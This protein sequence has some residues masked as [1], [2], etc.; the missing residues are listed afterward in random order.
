MIKRFWSRCLSQF[1]QGNCTGDVPDGP[2]VYRWAGGTAVY[3]GDWAAGQK[4]GYCVYTAGGEQWA[5]AAS[6]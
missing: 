3:E 4:H 5:G 6:R 1:L 2:G